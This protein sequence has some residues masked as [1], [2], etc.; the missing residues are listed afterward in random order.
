MASSMAGPR[1]FPRKEVSIFFSVVMAATLLV[2]PAVGDDNTASSTTSATSPFESTLPSVTSS[3]SCANYTDVC[4][5]NA[6]RALLFSVFFCPSENKSVSNDEFFFFLFFYF[7]LL[8]LFL[9]LAIV[10]AFTRLCRAVGLLPLRLHS[11]TVSAPAVGKPGN[12]KKNKNRHIR[13]VAANHCRTIPS[14]ESSQAADMRRVCPG[15][16]RRTLLFFPQNSFGLSY[17]NMVMNNDV[18]VFVRASQG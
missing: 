4:F 6:V 16:S 12:A 11:K 10:T 9:F 17:I 7:L 14:R 13:Y 1:F 18:P 15:K 5:T 2:A 3:A 8:L